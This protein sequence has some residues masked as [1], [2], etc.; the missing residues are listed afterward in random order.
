M[1]RLWT[2]KVFWNKTFHVQYWINWRSSYIQHTG[3]KAVTWLTH[4][5][6]SVTDICAVNSLSVTLNCYQFWISIRV[7]ESH[8]E[9]IDNSTSSIIPTEI[10]LLYKFPRTIW[11]Y[12]SR[13]EWSNIH[14]LVMQVEFNWNFPSWFKSTMFLINHEIK[15]TRFLL[16]NKHFPNSLMF[17]RHKRQ[18]S[19]NINITHY[20]CLSKN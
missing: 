13:N 3:N 14:D 4:I 20:C 9:K 15:S 18:S 5:G 6:Y 16:K 11:E 19:V 10:W 1:N 12:I 8:F 7:I 17:I 2:K